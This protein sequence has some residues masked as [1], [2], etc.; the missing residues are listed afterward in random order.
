MRRVNGKLTLTGKELPYLAKGSFSVA[1]ALIRENFQN[2][3]NSKLLRTTKYMPQ[4]KAIGSSDFQLFEMDIDLYADQGIFVR[5][6]LFDGELKGKLKLLKT[7]KSPGV[8]GNI[9][10]ISGRLLF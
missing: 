2:N 1:E 9:S 10:V 7:T 3:E 4:G 6:D 8:L 5:N